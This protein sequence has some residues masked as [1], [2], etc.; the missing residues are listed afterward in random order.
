MPDE[1]DKYRTMLGALFSLVTML[2]VFSYAVFKLD[3]LFGFEEYRVQEST[4]YE[5]FK[6]SEPFGHKNGYALAAGLIDFDA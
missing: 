4:R 6:P 2:T 1:S 5:F 3:N